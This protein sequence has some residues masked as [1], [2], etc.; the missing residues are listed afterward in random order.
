[1]LNTAASIG[2]Q[3]S[4]LNPLDNCILGEYEA[5]EQQEGG[6][7]VCSFCPSDLVG[8]LLLQLHCIR[9]HLFTAVLSAP[10]FRV[11][12]HCVKMLSSTELSLFILFVIVGSIRRSP[13]PN[14]AFTRSE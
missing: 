13:T 1:M 11:T 5:R 10:V 4:S 2:R 3:L 14:D 6:R 7:S 9:F 8:L 12:L